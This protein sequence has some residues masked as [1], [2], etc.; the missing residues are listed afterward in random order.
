VK[1]ILL[2]TT[3]AA[4]A[5]L[6]VF[7]TNR[8]A[9]QRFQKERKDR[10]LTGAVS[11]RFKALQDLNGKM[12][13]AHF[14]LN[15]SANVP[16]RTMV[17][18]D[19]RVSGPFQRFADSLNQY[20]VWLDSE[21]RKALD[22]V[23]GAFNQ[24]TF[25]IFLSLPAGQ[26]PS[27]INP[28]SY[29]QPITSPNWQNFLS[30]FDNATSL[31]R[32]RMQIPAVEE[33]LRE[34]LV[35]SRPKPSV[36]GLL[37][38]SQPGKILTYI[39]LALLIVAANQAVGVLSASNIAKLPFWVWPIL[40][41]PSSSIPL[42]LIFAIKGVKGKRLLIAYTSVL[43]A[44]MVFVIGKLDDALTSLTPSLFSLDPL[45][46]I[47]LILFVLVFAFFLWLID[48]LKPLPKIIDAEMSKKSA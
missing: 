30:S 20:S 22:S 16:P 2:A 7:L 31:L 37:A 1:D 48:Y 4:S 35:T 40:A 33:Y 14:K 6:A 41:V 24:V 29:A 25:A 42:A 11:T 23:R 21:A 28:T 38:R 32:D 47:I 45:S 34:T 15:F 19:E 17:E 46:L 27:T 18:Y 3:G 26:L 12:V 44:A 9:S 13:D 39:G 5:I 8:S 36:E 43:V 10:L